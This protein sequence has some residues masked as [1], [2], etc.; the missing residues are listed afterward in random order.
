[1]FFY[2]LLSSPW[3]RRYVSHDISDGS[4]IHKVLRYPLWRIPLL[5]LNVQQPPLSLVVLYVNFSDSVAKGITRI[6]S[7]QVVEDEDHY[8]SPAGDTLGIRTKEVHEQ[9]HLGDECKLQD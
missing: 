1:M 2:F 3:M 8:N 4:H 7:I 9:K 5:V 6:I